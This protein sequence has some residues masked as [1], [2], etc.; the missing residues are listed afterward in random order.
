MNNKK[1]SKYETTECYKIV[2]KGRRILFPPE[3][4]IGDRF[5]IYRVNS[6]PNE[7][8]MDNRLPNEPNNPKN[9][10]N[11]NTVFSQQ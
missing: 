11:E 6:L 1:N 10:K 3:F 8:K 2:P 5:R 7:N 4:E 9:E